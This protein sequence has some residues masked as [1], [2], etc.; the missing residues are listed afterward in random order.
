MSA[1]V[2]VIVEDAKSDAKRRRGTWRRRLRERASVAMWLEKRGWTG[3]GGR[4]R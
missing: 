3:C 4:T 1:C 2:C